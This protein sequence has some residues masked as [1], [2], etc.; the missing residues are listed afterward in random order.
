MKFY[1]PFTKCSA[2]GED[3]QCAPLPGCITD[4]QATL[5]NHFCVNPTP[6]DAHLFSWKH[7]KSSL[8][9]LSKTKVTSRLTAVSK[10]CKGPQPVDRKN[11]AL[12][13]QRCPFQ[14]SQS[15]G[16]LGRKFFHAVPL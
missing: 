5:K 1:I 16:S 15:H 6:Q 11:P 8:C 3:M 14:C 12:P 4:P 7:L 9:P 2:A 10:A 13:T